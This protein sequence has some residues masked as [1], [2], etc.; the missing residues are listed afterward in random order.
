M[1]ES[2]ESSD[3]ELAGPDDETEVAAETRSRRRLVAAVVVVL[4][5]AV[6]GVT[7]AV[8]SQADDEPDETV[9]AADG[10]EDNNGAP[11]E[12]TPPPTASTAPTEPPDTTE[13]PE[14]TPPVPDEP[15]EV[16]TGS[17]VSLDYDVAGDA[18]LLERADGRHILRLEDLAS[19]DGPDLYVYLST[20][21][22]D[23]PAGAFKD[24]FADLGSLQALTGTQDYDVP[25]DVDPT[26]FASV[27]IWC[28]A[29]SAPFGAAALSG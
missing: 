1:S 14:T 28:E 3:G 18:V 24:D 7:A 16:A 6:G 26:R 20:N 23:G 4:L 10:N 29:V 22:A 21:T 27:V 5:I 17:F 9:T 8:L 11:P 19:E 13:R 15:A 2:G 25:A 12:E